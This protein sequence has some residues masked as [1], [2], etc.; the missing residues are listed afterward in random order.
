MRDILINKGDD[1]VKQTYWECAFMTDMITN[2]PNLIVFNGV[3]IYNSSLQ[4]HKKTNRENNWLT[5]V[6]Q[7]WL[8]SFN[9]FF[10]HNFSKE[11]ND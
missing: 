4:C 9:A 10:K 11:I 7:L 3:H 2:T 6:N 1:N 8:R 5:L